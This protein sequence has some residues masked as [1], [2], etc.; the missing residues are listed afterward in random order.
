MIA[1]ANRENQRRPRRVPSRRGFTLLEVAL[2]LAVLIIITAIA[3]PALDRSMSSDS[4]RQSA[5]KLR[6][7]LAQARV[8]AMSSGVVQALRYE[9]ETG[10][11]IVEPWQDDYSEVNAT[12]FNALQADQQD[13]DVTLASNPA[14]EQLYEGVNFTAI[15]SQLSVRANYLLQN[16]ENE[17][18]VFFYPDGTT[19]TTTI[20]LQIG[21]VDNNDD[22]Y[23]EVKLNGLTGLS[24]RSE[25]LNA[26]ELTEAAQ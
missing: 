20:R 19:T 10:Y 24:K 4:L 12:D 8:E 23:I 2:V 7:S 6:A 11:Y 16:S 21:S 18:A 5:D 22:L 1:K 15:S 14:A 17:Q 25:F 13:D 26:D 9:P 3:W